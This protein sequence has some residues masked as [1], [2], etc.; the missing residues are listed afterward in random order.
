MYK[1]LWIFILWRLCGFFIFGCFDIEAYFALVAPGWDNQMHAHTA[2]DKHICVLYTCKLI[3]Y[4]YSH[5]YS[6]GWRQ[7]L[8][9]V[10][11]R[12]IK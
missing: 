1:T 12:K 11:L 7:I 9:V 5:Y 8:F 4:H 3:L 2:F 10:R 6:H